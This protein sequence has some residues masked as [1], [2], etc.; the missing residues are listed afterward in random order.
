MKYILLN[1]KLKF[2]IDHA[3]IKRSVYLSL[4]GFKEIKKKE[5]TTKVLLYQAPLIFILDY[6]LHIFLKMY[7]VFSYYFCRYYLAYVQSYYN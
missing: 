6:S 4:S 7:F 3:L 2:I 5:N 1:T